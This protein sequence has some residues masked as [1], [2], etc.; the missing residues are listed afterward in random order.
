MPA[1]SNTVHS[2]LRSFPF[3][4]R[5]NVIDK[6]QLLVPSGW[7]TWGKIKILRQG[8]DCKGVVE[9]WEGVDIGRRQ[10]AMYDDE[11]VREGGVV[12]AYEE[13]LAHL[14]PSESV[15]SDCAAE[16]SED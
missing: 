5:A 16:R 10:S 4:Y 12:S 6:T 14:A 9:N 1:P 8:F 15:S 3:S 2:A 7:D 11:A 13:T